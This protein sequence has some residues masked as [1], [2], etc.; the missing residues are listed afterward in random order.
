MKP[1]KWRLHHGF[2]SVIFHWFGTLP[3]DFGIVPMF[4]SINKIAKSP[5]NYCLSIKA[6]IKVYTKK[7]V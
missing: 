1:E 4:V 6:V 5:G 7:W 2:A 3:F